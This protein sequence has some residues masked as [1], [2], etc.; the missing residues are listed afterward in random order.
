MTPQLVDHAQADS[1]IVIVAVTVNKKSHDV[2]WRRTV[3]LIV[4]V[5]VAIISQSYCERRLSRLPAQPIEL[6]LITFWSTLHICRVLLT[7][8][9]DLKLSFMYFKSRILVL[10]SFFG[11]AAAYQADINLVAIYHHS[12]YMY[13]Q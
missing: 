9:R 5:A 3:C 4:A 7:I 8:W 10:Q 11:Q 6:T 13:W 12:R 2:A 1:C